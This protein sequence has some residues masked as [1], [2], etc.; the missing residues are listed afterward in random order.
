MPQASW[1]QPAL[2][3]QGAGS[4]AAAGPAGQRLAVCRGLAG[5][6]LLW[7]D[8]GPGRDVSSLHG[9]G[10]GAVCVVGDPCTP[11]VLF[12]V[13]LGSAAV[14]PPI[15]PWLSAVRDGETLL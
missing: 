6:A 1:H 12:D 4:L 15:L 8:P 9:R 3:L 10:A 2:L 14:R 7:P 11:Q 13:G 5:A